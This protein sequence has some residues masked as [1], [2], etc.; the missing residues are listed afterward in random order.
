MIQTLE[1]E[2]IHREQIES[3]GGFVV[4]P[5]YIEGMTAEQKRIVYLSDPDEIDAYAN[6][7]ALDLL[8]T[9]TTYGAALVLTNYSSVTEE[10]SPILYEYVE[11]FGADSDT[12]K[13]IIKKALKRVTT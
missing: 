12:V 10:D 8:E 11:L 3:R 13:S 9:Y 4:L 6:D 2:I 1:H 5:K 7:I